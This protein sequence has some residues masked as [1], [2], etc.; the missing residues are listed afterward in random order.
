M[1]RRIGAVG[2]DGRR[3]RSCQGGLPEGFLSGTRGHDFHAFAV[4]VTSVEDRA[5]S[6]RGMRCRS[7]Y[8]PQEWELDRGRAAEGCGIVA[9]RSESSAVAR[10]D[11][12]VV[13]IS[14]R[15]SPHDGIEVVPFAAAAGIA[16]V[17]ATC[18]GFGYE[19]KG[20]NACDPALRRRNAGRKETNHPTFPSGPA[21][22]ALIPY[23]DDGP[24]LVLDLDVRAGLVHHPIDSGG[25]VLMCDS[26]APMVVRSG[27][28][29]AQGTET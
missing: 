26:T 28:L 2:Q 21:P 23:G 16:R 1:V 15:A 4:E 10:A 5:M 24:R 7:E 22:A 19:T 20:V 17:V 25:E 3:A 18:H 27:H 6:H 14:M 8:G 12:A 13:R 29:S 9:S 11:L